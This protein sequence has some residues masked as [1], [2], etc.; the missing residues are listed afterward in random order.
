[1]ADNARLRLL[2]WWCPAVHTLVSG[3]TIFY[4]R[5][6]RAALVA[7]EVLEVGA[8]AVGSAE[9]QTEAARPTWLHSNNIGCCEGYPA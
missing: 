6:A 8:E 5:H 2:R 1:V 7:R 3:Q 9:A 4:R